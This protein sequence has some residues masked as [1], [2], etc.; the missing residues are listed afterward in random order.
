M[1]HTFS[2]KIVNKLN[3]IAFAIWNTNENLLFIARD[4]FGIKPLYYTNI[5]NSFVFASEIKAL[6]HLN[7][8]PKL[9]TIGIY[10]LV[11][12]G[13]AHTLKWTVFKN[14]YEV[15]PVNYIIVNETGLHSKII[16]S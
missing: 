16:G 15:E 12:I 5:N 3:G 10:E 2:R 6:F 9:D 8:E 7:V 1:I 11:G 13:P 14:I 4:H